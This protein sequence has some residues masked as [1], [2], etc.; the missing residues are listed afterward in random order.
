[1]SRSERLTRPTPTRLE[2]AFPSV[3]FPPPVAAPM[4][5]SVIA[6]GYGL[7]MRLTRGWSL[8]ILLVRLE[9]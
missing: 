8:V 7:V 2:L 6:G 1:M 3:T 4:D 9:V 5:S